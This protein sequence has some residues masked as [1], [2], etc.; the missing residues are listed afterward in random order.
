MSTKKRVLITLIVVLILSVSFILYRN[1]KNKTEVK[2][3]IPTTGAQYKELT[4]GVS[5]E[6]SITNKMGTAVS[7]KQEG[8]T[9]ILEYKSNNPNFNNQFLSK[10]GTLTFVKQIVTMDEKITISDINK[11]YGNYE[12]VL[13]GPYS[14]NGFNL[15]I[16]P[17]RGIAYIGH[18][19]SGIILEIWYFPPTDLRTFKNL[20]AQ[21]Y[22]ETLPIVQ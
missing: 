5:T 7:E 12:S 20:Y 14:T 2:V 15:Y 16:Y 17:E 19:E 22:S 11:E 9:K 18:Q 6:E 8:D 3:S 13:Y 1:Y 10:A 4:P 21:D